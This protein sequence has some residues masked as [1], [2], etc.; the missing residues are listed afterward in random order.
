MSFLKS[1]LVLGALLISGIAA[2]GSSNGV[3]ECKSGSGRTLVEAL[4]PVDGMEASIEITVDGK[5]VK[6]INQDLKDFLRM[7]NMKDKGILAP[8]GIE[9]SKTKRDISIVAY[10]DTSGKFDEILANLSSIG[11]MKRKAT[12]YGGEQINFSAKLN[13][14][15]PRSDLTKE[16]PLITLK[17]VYTYEI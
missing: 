16:L 5:S 6:Y 8:G 2:A 15:D 1:S 13:G 11:I 17:C 10:G 9:T 12:Q 4:I 3:I 7:N 14:L